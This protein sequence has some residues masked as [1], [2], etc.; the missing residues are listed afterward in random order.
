MPARLVRAVHA[1]RRHAPDAS[2][3]LGLAAYLRAQYDLPQRLALYARF[4]VA[5]TAFDALMRRAIWRASCKRFGHGVQIGSGVGFK[6]LETFEVGHGVFIGAGAYLQG[7]YDGICRIGDYAWIGPQSYFD[8]RH[9]IVEEYV[10]WGPGT[11]VLGS[12]H[13]GVP[14][15]RPILKTDLVIKPVVVR[16][17]AD[18]GTGAILLPGVTVG[19]GAIVG[20]GAVVTHDVPPY[21]IGAGVPARVLRRRAGKKPGPRA[22]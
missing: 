22:S 14:V 16:R 20:A 10:G 19:A 18:I 6:H 9:L 2:F 13:T 11:R 1:L 7:R 21:T 4:A 17:H 12:T 8:A 5:D 15:T 3:E